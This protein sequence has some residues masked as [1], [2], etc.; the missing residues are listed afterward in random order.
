ITPRKIATYAAVLVLAL[1][2]CL[3]YFNYRASQVV[4]VINLAEEP[5]L[6]TEE[7]R[8]QITYLVQ[9]SGEV[10]SPGVFEVLPGTRVMDMLELAGGANEYSETDRLNLVSFVR[11]GQRIDVPRIPNPT[12]D[13]IDILAHN[14]NGGAERININTADQAELTRL[15]GIGPQTA[16]GITAFRRSVGY[17]ESI[18]DIMNVHGIGE[19]LFS[20]IAPFITVD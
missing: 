3:I 6:T 16:S 11:D 17:F 4:A 13:R 9:V 10:H 1:I 20:R 18:E 12:L 14:G 15:P 19:G 2:I 5:F 8:A 7:R